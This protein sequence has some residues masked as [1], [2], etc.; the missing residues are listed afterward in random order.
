MA[1]IADLTEAF[2]L[3]AAGAVLDT[4]N[5]KADNFSGGVAT[6]ATFV[7][8]GTGTALAEFACS[9]SSRIARFNFTARA[10]IYV[11]VKIRVV[12]APATSTAVLSWYSG[13]GTGALKVGDVQVQPVAGDTTKF[14]F[15]LRDV[16]TQQWL[17]ANLDVGTWY[18][19]AVK[20]NPGS[21]T[22]HR[23]RLWSGATI[24]NALPDVDSGDL[25]A[26]GSTATAL[27]N[28]RLG[29]LSTETITV[30]FDDMIA[31]D[32]AWP[33]RGGTGGGGTGGP[34]A[35]LTE[36]FEAG[37]AGSNIATTN[38]IFDVIT[39]ATVGKFFSSPYAGSLA[40]RVNPTVQ[41]ALHRANL[42]SAAN[43]LWTKFAFR[44][45]VWPSTNVGILNIYSGTTLLAGVQMTPTGQIRVRD[46][47]TTRWTSTGTMPV[48]AYVEIALHADCRA[49]TEHLRMKTYVGAD[50]GGTVETENSGSVTFTTGVGATIDNIRLG[51]ASPD[52]C[53]F[54]F[55]SIRGD[56][57]NEPASIAPPPAAPTVD[58]GPDIAG[59]LPYD[60]VQLGATATGGTPPFTYAWTQTAGATTSITGAAT[61]TPT[62]TGPATETGSTLTFQVTVTDSASATA[63]DT[64]NV[65]VL[66]HSMWYRQ[67]G[68]WV[69]TNLK[70]RQAG[71]WV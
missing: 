30:R 66:P 71:A 14:Q 35:E 55:D 27:D 26:T 3:G 53:D 48:G 16:N 39:G 19:V 31:D 36:N 6:N 1:S 40:M 7:G 41:D 52:T 44:A 69:P 21:T 29:I 24:D 4:S 47:A 15:R 33:S 65:V 57:A 10:T 32:S 59:V 45:A 67:G 37:T 25:A 13:S 61:A 64:V 49:G 22:G 43:N 58:A 62:T 11:D 18:R 63:S 50:R 38:T 70:Y 60:T 46:G 17:S 42:A 8:T 51:V 9:A 23:L 2:D 5:T 12:V 34:L 20:A 68:A 56:T 54:R 28:L